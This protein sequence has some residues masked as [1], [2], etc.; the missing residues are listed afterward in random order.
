M[1]KKSFI[2]GIIVSLILISLLTGLQAV[3]VAEANMIPIP[4]AE[5]YSPLPSTTYHNTTVMLDVC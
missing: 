1:I 2:A 4:T 3:M 5:I